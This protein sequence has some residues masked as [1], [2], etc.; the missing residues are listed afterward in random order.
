[1]K[2]F[3]ILAFAFA[4]E[5]DNQSVCPSTACWTYKSSDNSC[6]LKAE[7]SEL[8]CSATHMT[9]K[10]TEDVFGKVNEALGMENE[11]EFKEGDDKPWQLSC[12]LGSCNMTYKVV[13]DDLVFTVRIQQEGNSRIRS[14]VTSK[15]IDLGGVKV[16]TTPFGVGVT[17][18]CAYAMALDVSSSAFQ[19]QPVS[20]SGM[21]QE[22]GN[23]KDGF[24][25][26]LKYGM[27]S[28]MLLGA[29]QEVTVDWSVTTL[30]D[31]SFFFDNCQVH[32]A[33]YA[34]DVVKGSCYSKVLQVQKHDGTS[35]RQSFGYKTFTI[36]NHH[37]N[38]QKI[39]CTIKLCFDQIC[40][41]ATTQEKC[42]PKDVYD[43]TLL[44]YQ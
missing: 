35:T 14:D 29:V 7:C 12:S 20:I 1:M 27:D 19:V 17:F 23:L 16:T 36:A 40:G 28:H 39:T 31:V 30:P 43:F 8:E 3:S 24:A 6:E 10:W 44:G 37:S 18:H 38:E 22:R 2:F 33:T 26:S 25:M 5:D 34:I 13:G 42:P 32:Q 15:V 21:K 4:L 41:K 9:M 11:P